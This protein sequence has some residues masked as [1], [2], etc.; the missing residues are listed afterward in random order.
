MCGNAKILKGAKST[1]TLSSEAKKL[2]K[3]EVSSIE[4]AVKDAGIQQIHPDKMEAF[5]EELVSRLKDSNKD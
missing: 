5:A 1:M 2:D 4:N 3:N